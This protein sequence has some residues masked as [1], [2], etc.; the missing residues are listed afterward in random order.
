MS[1][2]QT[3]PTYAEVIIVDQATMKPTFNPIWLDWFLRLASVLSG[4]SGG[5]ISHALLADLQ[6]GMSGEYFHLTNAQ[7]TLATA[8]LQNQ[9]ANRV[10]AGPTGGSPAAPA[11]RALVAADLPAGTG[12]VTS[13]ALA[14][15]P[16][17]V[18]DVSGSP[19]TG[20]GTLT[21][22]MDNQNANLILA[23]PSTGS[24]A[25]PAFRS[26]VAADIP[27]TAVTPGS[28]TSTN[29][30]VDAQGRIT[31]ASNGS[32][33]G[34]AFGTIAVSGQSDIVSDSASDT[35]TIAAGANITLTTDAGTDTLTIAASA[36]GMS[37]GSSNPAQPAF[38]TNVLFYRTDLGLIIYYDG[39]R[40]LTAAKFMLPF[41]A[42]TAFS[43]AVAATNTA[44]LNTNIP[45]IPTYDLWLE[46][47]Y[48][49]TFVTTTTN[50]TN[51]WTVDFTKFPATGA[52]TSIGSFDTKTDTGSNFT[53]H[54]VA[55][56]AALGTTFFWLV[57]GVTKT[58][59]PGTIYLTASISYRLIIT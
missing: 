8:I 10:L 23:G 28:Y 52:G 2:F 14:A 3:P 12:T 33:G 55:V 53:Q 24:A 17:S 42:Y 25:Q 59:S 16:S 43:N 48:A 36:S 6:G 4:G 56:N 39:T 38:G 29:L 37:S 20:S 31:A 49:T 15:T 7:Y 47:I 11:F 54:T 50:G 51:Y 35:L 40:W 22:S 18:F 34:N 19:V 13:V 26:M 9:T 1:E 30:T 45:F 58:L 57:A 27:N 21:L 5:S 46:T 32:A 41:S 44:L